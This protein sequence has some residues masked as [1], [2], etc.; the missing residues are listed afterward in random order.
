MEAKLLR[1]PVDS[2][3]LPYG[4]LM[5][6]SLQRSTGSIVRSL[7]NSQGAGHVLSEI[8]SDVADCPLHPT[9]DTATRPRGWLTQTLYTKA[10]GVAVDFCGPK[11]VAQT[12]RVVAWGMLLDCRH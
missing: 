1:S 6:A 12:I 5:S 3:R 2:S 8:R 4:G 10:Y 11:M 9:L 7:S